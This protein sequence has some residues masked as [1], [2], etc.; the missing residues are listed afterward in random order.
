MTKENQTRGIDEI[1]FMIHKR[2]KVYN[3]RSGCLLW[4]Y[5]IGLLIITWGIFT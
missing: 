2:S 5:N 4:Q 1:I 3:S